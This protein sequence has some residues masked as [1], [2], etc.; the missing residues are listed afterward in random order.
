MKTG[1]TSYAFLMEM[2][3]VCAFFLLSSSVFVMSFAKAEQLSRK[4][5][6]LNH[7]VLEASNA[8][9]ST[10]AACGGLD[11]FAALPLAEIEA[12]SSSVCSIKIE[13]AQ[14]NGLLRIT[15]KALDRKNGSVLYTLEGTRCLLS[16]ERTGA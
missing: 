1:R 6:T 4:A 14:D 2:L 3:W 11:D 16:A 15:V 8:L 9:E 12:E 5:E 13:T 10:F 7:A